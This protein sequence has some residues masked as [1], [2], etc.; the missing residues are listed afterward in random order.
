MKGFRTVLL[1]PLAARLGTLIGG[2]I[3]GIGTFDPGLTSRV[4]AWIAAGCFIAVDIIVAAMRDRNPQ[5][6]LNR[7]EA[8]KAEAEAVKNQEGR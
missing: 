3:G 4:E 8:I 1:G 5:S 2:A 7:A 6:I